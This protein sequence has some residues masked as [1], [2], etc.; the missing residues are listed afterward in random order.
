MNGVGAVEVPVKNGSSSMAK[1]KELK[2]IASGLYGSFISRN[3][4]VRGYWGVGKLCLAAQRHHT[5]VVHLDL[6]SQSNSLMSAEFDKLV[7]GYHNKL[8]KYLKS[9]HLPS[10]WVVS[11]VIQLDFSPEY[12][13]KYVPIETWGSLFKLR[14]L[15]IDDR[16]KSYGVE[17]FNYCGSH[18][19]SKELR[20]TVE[21]L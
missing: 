7:A 11:A 2:N 8:Q 10:N 19:P 17:C 6:L 9:K 3:N 15:I 21:R 20:S 1:R 5:N 16:G 12:P 13:E 4:D 14:V 18:D